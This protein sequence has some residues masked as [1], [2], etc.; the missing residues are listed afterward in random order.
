[1]VNKSLSK[2][3]ALQLQMHACQMFYLFVDQVFGFNW[4]VTKAL[5]YG[6]L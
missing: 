3:P 1:M 2:A 4:Y 6:F 5:M